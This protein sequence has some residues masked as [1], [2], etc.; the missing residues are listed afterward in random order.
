M[1]RLSAFVE[2]ARERL[3]EDG[4]VLLVYFREI[5]TPFFYSRKRNVVVEVTL[6]NAR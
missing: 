5:N 4:S 1:S 3:L 6:L 2:S